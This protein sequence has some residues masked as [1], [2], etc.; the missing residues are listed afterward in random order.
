MV[1]HDTRGA[2]IFEKDINESAGNLVELNL[3]L[4]DNGIY[5]LKLTSHKFSKSI[6]L[7]KY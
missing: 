3:D 7:V 1:V 5:F 2:L 4:E 6:K